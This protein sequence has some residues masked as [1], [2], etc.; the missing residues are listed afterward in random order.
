MN[1]IKEITNLA[2]PF[3]LFILFTPG[4]LFTLPDESNTQIEKTIVHALLFLGAY[5]LLRTVFAKYY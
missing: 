3:I 4:L 2:V 5:A 1:N